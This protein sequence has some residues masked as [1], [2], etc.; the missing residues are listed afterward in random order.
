MHLSTSSKT[1]REKGKRLLGSNNP[2]DQRSGD[3]N[4]VRKRILTRL[5]T[6]HKDTVFSRR[7]RYI[8]TGLMNKSSSVRVDESVQKNATINYCAKTEVENGIPQPY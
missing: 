5:A 1:C 2:K 4:L 7:V 3:H 8:S 6:S